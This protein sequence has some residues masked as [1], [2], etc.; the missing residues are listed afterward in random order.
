MLRLIQHL[1][2]VQRRAGARSSL[3]FLYFFLIMASY[4]VARVTRDTLFLDKYS[5]DK[6][7]FADL[8][9]ALLVGFVISA[10]VS[11]SRYVTLRNLLVGSLL[12]FA[13]NTFV[14]WWLA[15]FHSVL[16][17]PYP[18]LYV[19]VGLFGV[20]APAQVWILGNYVLTPREAKR[21]FGV[22]AGGSILGGVFGGKVSS[23]IAPLYGTPSLLLGVGTALLI[24]V[25]LVSVVWKKR[26][27]EM[28][29]QETQ[30]VQ[31]N[32]KPPAVTESLKLIWSRPYLRVLATL[33][34][35]ANTTTSMAGWQFKALARNFYSGSEL[36]AFFGD[37]Y[38][39]A[40]LAA[41]FLQV[42]V[43]G[44]LL[45]RFGLGP[46]L[47][48]VPAAICFVS[49]GVLGWGLIT[50]W[51][52]VGLRCCMNVLQYSIDRPSVE[53]LYLPVPTDIKNQVKSFIDTVV[54]RFGD[55]SAAAIQAI[56]LWIFGWHAV[57][58][59]QA[60]WITMALA[61]TWLVIAVAT[62]RRYV[63][64]LRDTIRQ[65][66][67]DAETVLAPV[68]DRST[69]AIFAENLMAADPRD[70]L[71]GL[72]LFEISY[73]GSSHPAIRSLLA[74]PT[75]EVRQ[76]AICALAAAG[77][78]SVRTS[79]EV[80]LN[81]PSLGVR[82]EA[83]L[84]LTHHAHIDPL[85]RIRELGDFSD[86][87]VRSAMVA[88]L[89]RPGETQNVV[90]ART[91][92]DGMV[93]ER[94]SEGKRTRLEAARLLS[95]LPPEF[96][97]QFRR[98]L[99]DT[100]PD[101]VR[102]A[103]RSVGNLRARG[104]VVRL[105]DHLGNSELAGDAAEALTK[106]GDRLVGTLRDYL[107]DTS[108][109]L[110][111]RRQI[112]GVLAR[113][114]TPTAELVLMQSLLEPDTGFRFRIICALNKLQRS[115]PDLPLDKQMIE[116][117]LAAEILG[118]YRSFQILGTLE[119]DLNS[120][121]IMAGALRRSMQ[122]EIE[123]IF[124][125]L[126]LLLPN[127]DFHSAYFSLQS[128]SGIVHDTAL[129]FLENVLKPQL[130]DA[131]IPLIDRHVS[132]QERIRIASRMVGVRCASREEAVAAL[133]CSEDSWLRSCGAYAVGRLGLRQFEFHLDACLNDTNPLLRETAGSAKLRLQQL[134]SQRRSTVLIFGREHSQLTGELETL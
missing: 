7:P 100:D 125:L 21:V 37:F 74:H 67:L 89:A 57:R 53:L 59:S 104:F 91:L 22:M 51:A 29:S 120:E 46:A 122:H 31:K 77:D 102:E 56:F 76:R 54:W 30:E 45:K 24:S 108:R 28:L 111:T 119:A 39:Y 16:A 116:T 9:V 38:F 123:R 96:P 117:V 26:P 97:E 115:Q 88:F 68:L 43:T 82:T 50:I 20:L 103:I 62:Y 92:L 127:H 27:A 131:L 80:L 105:V 6:L 40:G 48:L 12:F 8:T 36:A 86:F 42:V 25:V 52:A 114:G 15:R 10:Y 75:S 55:G 11:V 109:P 129:E 64:T 124:R 81:D 65:Y 69:S 49:I 84:Y 13:A 132:D 4:I 98:L 66:R 71:Y 47:L 61:V 128:A 17:W 93:R 1:M 110:E 2:P 83:L 87:S 113:I 112:V 133:L 126:S 90:A 121:E 70:I 106:F 60:S 118:H 33:V 134:A 34:L 35:I 85:T 41:L 101:I 95:T 78:Q 99:E 72:Q 94:G 107:V 44:Y 32:L 130:R 18:V 5:P 73:R 58:A 23:L 14:F 79:I 63:A 3:L 19:W